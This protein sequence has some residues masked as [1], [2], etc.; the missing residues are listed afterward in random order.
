MLFARVRRVAAVPLLAVSACAAVVAVD[1]TAAGPAEA[2]VVATADAAASAVPPVVAPA[3]TRTRGVPVLASRQHGRSGPAASGRRSEATREDV[4]EKG[5]EP[6]ERSERQHHRFI[7]AAVGPAR[8]SQREFKVPASV[9]LA[10]AILESGWGQSDLTRDD[11]NYFGMK[12]FGSPGRIAI[13]CHDYRTTECDPLTCWE[14]VDSFRVYRSAT[15]SFRDH[16]RQLATL[17]RYAPAFAYTN[18]PDRFAAEIH[19]SGY[20]TDPEY[21]TKLV[22]LMTRY[23]LYR[24]DRR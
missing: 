10:Q 8:A 1:T 19:K 5:R 14:I 23:N 20:A 3:V 11:R 17:D 24:Y 18:D 16:G 22:A 9:T 2:S 12:C 15:D 4:A 6:R 13:G 7:A 21:P